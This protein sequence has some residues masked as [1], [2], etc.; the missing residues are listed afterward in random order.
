MSAVNVPSPHAPHR[1]W[2]IAVLL[3]IGV[4]VNFFDRVNV[5]V[6]YS[7]LRENWHITAV[8]FGLLSSAYNWSYGALQIPVGVMLD[9][10]GV[11]RIGRIA[12]FLWSMASFASGLATGVAS[13]FAARLLLGI[14]EAPTFPANSKAIGYW[15]PEN[16]R[17]FA[18]SINDSAAKFASAIGVPILGI[19]LL[20]FG[21]R[22][23][24][25]FTGFVSF[26]YFLLFWR[27]YRNPGEDPRLSPDERRLISEGHAQPESGPAE[28]AHGAPLLYLLRQPQVMGATI[29]FAAYNY[30]FY[31]VLTW[32]PSYLSMSLHVNL[33][34]SALYTS[35]P[36]LVATVSDLF[37]G[38]WLVDALVRRGARPWLVRQSVLVGGLALGAALYGAGFAHT[39]RA[40]LVWISIAMAGL[41][42]MAPVGWSVPSLISPRESVGRI[43]GIMNFATQIAAISAPIVT[44]Y[45]AGHNNF[46]GAFLIAAVVLAIGI[47]GYALLLG[48]LRVIPEPAWPSSKVIR[49]S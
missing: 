30:V 5:S 22:W 29:G 10:W 43:G 47:L 3:G 23:S 48:K 41:G 25:M 49:T 40:A 6:A 32:L 31:L 20:R 1:R 44:G 17:S 33:L 21:W 11:G 16:E 27:V 28:H 24:F 18:T 19:L 7:A 4:L 13:F 8:T 15:F 46:S 36:W 2:R 42:A 9:R 34:N 12:A 39:P 38:G 45:F 37:I 14:G 26:L 35:I